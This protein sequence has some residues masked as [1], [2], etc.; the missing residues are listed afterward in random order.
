MI[1]S[2]FDTTKL[3]LNAT[4]FPALKHCFLPANVSGLVATDSAGSVVITGST[5]FI[6][7]SVGFYLSGTPT[8]TGSWLSPAGNA[9]IWMAT[10]TFT[11]I[12][13]NPIRF[14]EAST[15]TGVDLYQNASA[16]VTVDGTHYTTYAGSGISTSKAIAIAIAAGGATAPRYVIGSDKVITTTAATVALGVNNLA[17]T[18]TVAVSGSSNTKISSILVWQFT[19]MPTDASTAIAWMAENPGYGYPSWYLKT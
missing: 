16:G 5:A 9:S 6:K 3:A 18:S 8:M 2:I 14:G 10:G 13:S 11:A 12:G 7:D 1:V 19:T 4:N 17:P 15:T